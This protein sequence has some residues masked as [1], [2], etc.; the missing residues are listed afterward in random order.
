MIDQRLGPARNRVYIIEDLTRMVISYEIYETR[1]R[2]VSYISYEMT[3]P[4][5]FCL[6]YDSLKWN[7]I[8][9]IISIKTHF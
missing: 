1:Q 4:V 2:L 5:R 9:F 3:T 7:F 8:A 6:S